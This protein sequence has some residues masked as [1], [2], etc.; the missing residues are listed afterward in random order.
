M[1][2][3]KLSIILLIYIFFFYTFLLNSFYKFN[4]EFIIAISLYI[5]LFFFIFFRLDFF[6]VNYF[7][8]I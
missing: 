1:I 5:F 3:H 6:N 2:K 7:Y 4:E 8:T